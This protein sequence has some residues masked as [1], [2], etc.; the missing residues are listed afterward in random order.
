[1]VKYFEG[2]KICGLESY[3]DFMGYIFMAYLATLKYSNFCGL[4]V[5]QNPC[6]IKPETS[7]L[8]NFGEARFK[9]F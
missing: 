7:A 1:M 2:L 5:P 3:N 9:E 6:T 4:E 8:L